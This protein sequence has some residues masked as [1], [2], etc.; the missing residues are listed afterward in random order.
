MILQ[1]LHPEQF[2]DHDENIL[3][4]NKDSL[5]GRLVQCFICNEPRVKHYVLRSRSMITSPNIFG[6][7]A[8]VKPS[9]NLQFCDYNLIQVST[10][11]KCGFSS[12]DLNFFK[13][14]NNNKQTQKRFLKQKTTK[15]WSVKSTYNWFY[16]SWNPC[17]YRLDNKWYTYN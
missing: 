9:G 12:N 5:M 7:P 3:K 16:C 14:Q 17:I 1:I 6:V 15:C 4:P 10:C 2:T 8:Y 13:K 11:P